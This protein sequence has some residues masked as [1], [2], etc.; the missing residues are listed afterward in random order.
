MGRHVCRH[1]R[2][3]AWL[4]AGAA[5]CGAGAT[6]PAW[7]DEPWPRFRGADG[8]GQGGVL[9]FPHQWADD[10]WA[11]RVSLPGIG[12]AS[13]VVW[14]GG[15]Y[16]ASAEVDPADPSRGARIV[17]RHALADGGLGW[18]VRL[19]GP[20][21]RHHTFNSSASSTVTA[22]PRG[23]Y[24]AWGTEAGIHL[25][26]LG[27]DGARRWQVDL[28]PFVSEHG[29][30]GTPALHG[31]LVIVAVEHE[32]PSFV[33]AFDEATGRE[34]WRLPRE[35]GRATYATPLITPGP[36]EQLIVASTTHGLTGIDP[37]SGRKFWE[38]R[39]FPKRAVS[40]PLLIGPPAGRLVIGTC[41]D[42]GG[43]NALVALR[44]PT[45]DP[46]LGAV[47]PAVAFQLDRGVAPYVPTP[48]AGAAGLYLWG[49]R[50]VVTCVDPTSGAVRWRGRVG[51]TFSASP[52]AVG[53]T[54][55]NVSTDGEVV[56]IADGAEFELLGRTALGEESRSSPAVAAGMLL[57]RSKSKL[58][59][60]PALP[61]AARVP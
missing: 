45:G 59:A 36:G 19:P 11:W 44:L 24:W 37:D 38:R 35:P 3:G 51:G 53:G 4:L 47:E 52:V 15:V 9:R 21:S 33:A 6:P 41:G 40:S 42:G 16:T 12:H 60:V 58:H 31:G 10:G 8:A 5:W 22:G 46:A 29:Y 18:E 26:A 14:D 43:D 20:F 28:G 48:V 34:R 56:V 13:P 55:V 50:G 23:V 30:A 32:G 54:V 2:L 17:S 39:C 49:D 57:F 1:S 7:A 61:A 25:V 27:H